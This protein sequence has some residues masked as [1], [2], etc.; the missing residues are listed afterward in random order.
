V[1]AKFLIDQSHLERFIANRPGILLAGDAADSGPLPGL[2]LE[3]WYGRRVPADRVLIAA[4]PKAAERGQEVEVPLAPAGILAVLLY[5]GEDGELW[6]AWFA[7]CLGVRIPEILPF[8][9]IAAMRAITA[10]LLHEQTAVTAAAAEMHLALARVRQDY[11]Q[12]A[13]ASTGLV[14][15]LANRPSG[16]MTLQSVAEPSDETI[17]LDG[18]NPMLTQPL[19][20]RVDRIAAVAIATGA[21]AGNGAD[22]LRVRLSGIE[23][24]RIFG[25][26]LLPADALHPGWVELELPAPVEWAPETAQLELHFSSG[27]GGHLD[28]QLDRMPPFPQNIMTRPG[29]PSPDAALAVKVWC[30]DTGSRYVMP[31][32]WDWTEL[33]S[34]AHP[35]GIPLAMPLAAY[36]RVRVL[37]G[38]MPKPYSPVDLDP[39]VIG[40]FGGRQTLVLFPL[41]N[42]SGMDV[43][44]AAFALRAGDARGLAVAM[45]LQPV[46]HTINGET[47]LLLSGSN[48]A[49]S[50]WH[51]FG[52]KGEARVVME[53]PAGLGVNLQLVVLLDGTAR[54]A[55]GLS[56]L[57][58]RKIMLHGMNPGRKARRQAS[59]IA[60][61]SDA[62]APVPRA[63]TI[64][65]TAPGATEPAITL[66][67]V[68]LDE[69]FDNG[70]PYRHLDMRL[71]KF[72]VDGCYWPFLKFRLVVEQRHP[73]LEFRDIPSWP[74]SLKNWPASSRD[75]HGR[76]T[77]LFGRPAE[78]PLVR[79]EAAPEDLLLIKGLVRCL[80]GLVAKAALL[81]KLD[82]D[83]C[84]IWADT[85]A[86]LAVRLGPIAA[87]ADAR[88]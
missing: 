21:V 39:M 43:I 26:W 28:L 77:R 42:V 50:G 35:A 7:D 8:D 53:L 12:I 2:G 57:E 62:A 45:W 24:G 29:I 51:A 66:R 6:R 4:G 23:S 52:G 49:W 72:S 14:R 37:Q 84:A 87:L 32:H 33:G 80:P 17:R 13:A 71:V 70:G 54:P 68:V 16:E 11:E 65:E 82:P 81:A 15:A 40:L 1:T 22:H 73:C 31:E 55:S 44:D 74:P 36:T 79:A 20:T 69:H 61:G 41:V 88:P 34:A 67:E 27:N 19:G 48:V 76:L 5:P 83:D 10:R 3:I 78:L 30:A 59:L 63:I 58:I 46:G 85:A 18:E 56:L 64:K 9:P 25:S 38:G 75:D 60:S 86:E 47:D